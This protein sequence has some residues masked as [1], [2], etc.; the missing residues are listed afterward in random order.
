LRS[1]G[2]LFGGAGFFTIMVFFM[3]SPFHLFRVGVVRG[4][5]VVRIK[6]RAIP[7]GMALT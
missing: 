5:E 3:V 2:D 1:Q 7:D 4:G 6:K